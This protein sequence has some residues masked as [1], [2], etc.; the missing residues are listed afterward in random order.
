MKKVLLLSLAV[1]LVGI[2]PVRAEET[3]EVAGDMPGVSSLARMCAGGGA[4]C[5]SA[6]SSMVAA[7]DG[8]VIV[9]SGEKLFKYDNALNLVKEVE[10]PKPL[11][12]EAPE[13]VNPDIRASEPL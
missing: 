12:P 13:A 5:C 7:Q 8:G 1:L 9:L 4:G 6:G 11:Q 10:L 3:G 2:S